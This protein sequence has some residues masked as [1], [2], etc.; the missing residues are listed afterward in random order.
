V[1][2]AKGF[3]EAMQPVNAKNGLEEESLVI[4]MTQ[5]SGKKK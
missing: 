3:T 2:Q 1:V 4:H 5:A